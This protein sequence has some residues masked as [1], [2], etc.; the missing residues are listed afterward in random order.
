LALAARPALWPTAARLVPPAWWRRWRPSPLPPADYLRFRTQT[1]YGDD[2]PLI[3]GDLIAYLEWC[4]R[5]G[6]RAR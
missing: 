5:M 3:P 6:H 2:G 4:R 1:M